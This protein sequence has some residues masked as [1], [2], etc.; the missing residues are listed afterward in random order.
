MA[1]PISLGVA[2]TGVGIAGAT[3]ALQGASSACSAY[4]VYHLK[5]K[6]KK[7]GPAAVQN[8]VAAT[9]PAVVP[10]QNT[11]VPF[12]QVP[13]EVT[14]YNYGGSSSLNTIPNGMLTNGINGGNFAWGT[15]RTT[16][17]VCVENGRP[18]SWENKV[19]LIQSAQHPPIQSLTPAGAL[20]ET[21]QFA[22][23]AASQP[24]QLSLPMYN[25]GSKISPVQEIGPPPAYETTFVSVP[26]KRDRFRL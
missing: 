11:V 1:D 25:S 15:I 24:Q 19:E 9:Q 20:S 5:R 23:P 22:Y 13:P 21:T 8:T 18:V 4:K 10:A 6:E 16:E 17:S 26:R 7:Q 14:S 3:L 12:G 2:V